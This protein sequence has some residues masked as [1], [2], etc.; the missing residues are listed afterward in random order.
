MS[1]VEKLDLKV[2]YKCCPYFGEIIDDE[3]WEITKEW[4]GKSEIRDV[5]IQIH[6]Y[7]FI[8]NEYQN[9]YNINVP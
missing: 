7:S 2:A 5:D 1:I 6:D 3:K 8:K 9:T 4:L